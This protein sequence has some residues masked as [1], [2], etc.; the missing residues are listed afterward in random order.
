MLRNGLKYALITISVLLG[1]VLLALILTQTAWF[2]SFVK[3]KVQKIAASQLNGELTIGE[4]EGDFFQSLELNDVFLFMGDS[5]VASFESLKLNYHLRALFKKEILIDSVILKKPFV[6]IKQEADSSLNLQHLLLESDKVES[7]SS[8][9][10]FPF[11]IRAPYISLRNGSVKTSTGSRFIPEAVFDF[12]LLAGGSYSSKEIEINLEALNF[13]TQNPSLSVNEISTVFKKDKSG[14]S[15]DSLLIRT[16]GSQILL[17]GDMASLTQMNGD[18]A[19]NP[20]NKDELF[21]F[22]PSFKLVR[23]PQIFADFVAEN[24]SATTKIKLI[25]GEET[26]VLNAGFYNLNNAVNGEKIEVP[27]QANLLIESVSP[28]NWIELGET[29]SIINGNISI[30]GSSLFDLT[31]PVNIVADLK[32]SVYY[33]NT[34]NKFL[35]DGKY[36]G[37]WAEANLDLETGFG[38]I[39]G[40]AKVQNVDSENPD[41]QLKLTAENINPISF[42]PELDS[43]MLNA[44]L[45]VKGTGFSPSKANVNAEVRVFSSTVYGLAVDS[46]N[47]QSH[48]AKN[49][50]KLDTLLAFVSGAQLKGSGNFNIESTQL[51]SKL[52]LLADSLAFLNPLLEVPVCFDSLGSTVFVAGKL[53]SIG[54]YGDIDLKNLEGYSVKTKELEFDFSGYWKGENLR[55]DAKVKTLNLETGSILW[56]SIL[57]N[58]SYT[59]EQI[60]AGVDALWK[61]TLDLKLR[62]RIYPG[63]TLRIELPELDIK[64]FLSDFYLPDTLQSVELYNNSVSVNSLH[65]KNKEQP[66]FNLRI[67]GNLAMSESDN[68]QLTLDNFNIGPFNRFISAT[69]SIRGIISTSVSVKGTLQNPVVEGDIE[70]KDLGY[71]NISPGNFLSQ[72]NYSDNMGRIEF[73]LPDLASSGFLS[74]PMTISSDTSGFTFAPPE[75]FEAEFKVDSL[76]VSQPEIGQIRNTE[77]SGNINVG[78]KAE[79][80]INS[81]LIYGDINIEQGKFVHPVLGLN[82]NDISTKIHFDGKKINIDTLLVQ[83]PKGY[84]LAKGNVDFDT[85]IISG[86][87]SNST[88]TVKASN[89]E[90]VKSRKMELVIDA[91]TSVSMANNIP[92]FGGDIDIIRSEFYLSELM[93]AEDGVSESTD[94][95]LLIQALAVPVDTLSRTVE[96]EKV[97]KEVESEIDF[98][99]NLKGRINIEPRNTWIKSDNINMELR[100]DVDLVKTGPDFEIFGNIDVVRGYYIFYGRRLKID[101]GEIIFQGGEDFDPT[102]NIKAEYTYRDSEKVKRV[103]G[104]SITGLLSD[105]KISFTLDDNYLSEGDAVSILVFGRTSDEMSSSGQS[106]LVSAAGSK[107]IAKVLTSQLSKTLGARFNLDMIEINATE[108][109]Q[110]AAFVVGKYITNNLFVT[111]QRGFGETDGEEI[112]PETVT[113][114]YE[115]NRIFFLHLQSGSSKTSG[116]DIILK[117]EEKRKE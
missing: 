67:S 55:A 41:Y 117:L 96:K 84:L 92:E 101:E 18:L 36:Q 39:Y 83:Q 4:I 77:I 81:P 62:T 99:K 72:L 88:L 20:L 15:I 85:T 48:F 35:I 73:N 114:E 28:E 56:D 109:W 93:V 50:L 108:N 3:N 104:L 68:I 113:L 51:S 5:A 47:I 110:S 31:S 63:D 29:N 27:Y 19:V 52:F 24:D 75:T 89:F 43:T 21:I 10:F 53:D 106:G 105:P 33:G 74:M 11:K 94:E 100:G 76:S 44:E 8:S 54:F 91:N 40:E 87:V 78:L 112:T 90:V 37:K 38:R 98:L 66:D 22:V 42:V 116:L 6:F 65:L 34:F 107:M 16:T 79:G 69:D 17:N 9:S 49:N 45:D 14:I 64:S 103:L 59:P 71:G 102:M 12:N 60:S 58:A 30:S 32:N 25:N 7:K 70:I 82:Y 1:I 95:P 115:L 46:V 97:K 23:S 80:R 2:R 111:Y 13:Q 26:I 86:N 61:D 57:V